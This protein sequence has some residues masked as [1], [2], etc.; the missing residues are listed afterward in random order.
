MDY[1]TAMG[2]VQIII[3]L[4]F[5]LPI[6]ALVLAYTL[7]KTNRRKMIAVLIVLVP[8]VGF[9]T[10]WWWENKQVQKTDQAYTEKVHL[11]F[12]SSCRK[13]GEFIYRTIENID[14]ILLFSPR[15]NDHN[16]EYLKGEHGVDYIDRKFD[17]ESFFQTPI[18]DEN[19]YPE[20]LGK[21]EENFRNKY[22]GYRY[23][24]VIDPVDGKRYR[25]TGKF[26]EPWKRNPHSLE[27]HRV[28]VLEKTPVSVLS[29]PQPRYG[30]TYEDISTPEERKYWV[31]GSSLKIIDLQTNG[32]IAERIIYL[33]NWETCSPE[34]KYVQPRTFVQKVLKPS[35]EK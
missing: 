35:L 18:Q 20:A 7:P 31:T 23:I 32:I 6:L 10:Y 21:D 2:I 3:F 22:R 24:E 29:T 8:I 5:L 9:P 16:K 30:V 14:G 12:K 11:L 28:F 15:Q 27:G 4:I 17:I 34:Y 33:H 13:A 19:K 25:Y 1:I 26:D